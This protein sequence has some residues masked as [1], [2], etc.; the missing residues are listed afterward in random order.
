[1]AA[2]SVRHAGHAVRSTAFRGII[3]FSPIG[4][5]YWASPPATKEMRRT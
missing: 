4:E 2:R 1:V 3:L 5:P